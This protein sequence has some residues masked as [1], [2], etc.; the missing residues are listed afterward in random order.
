MHV[1]TVHDPFHPLRGREVREYRNRRRIC[2]LA[3]KTDRPFIVMVDGQP[4][5]RKDWDQSVGGDQVVIVMMLPEGGGGGGSSPLRIIGMLAVVAASFVVGPMVGGFIGGALG[6]GAAASAAIGSG[7]VLFGGSMLVNA[8]APAP[9]QNNSLSNAASAPA[10]SPT[11]S[12]QAQGNTARLGAPIPVQYGRMRIYPDFA[13]QPY[14]EYSDNEQYLYELLMI[15]QGEYSIEAVQIGNSPTTSFQNVTYEIVQPGAVPT[16]FPANVSQSSEVS[17]QELLTNTPVGPFV[18][19]AAGTKCTSIGIDVVCP[20]GLYY[21]NDGGGLDQRSVIFKIEARPIDQSGNPTGTGAWTT[22]NSDLQYTAWTPWTFYSYGL[23]PADT[24]TAHYQY[25]YDW[26]QEVF[27][28]LR[29]TRSLI[30][31]ANNSITGATTTPIRRSL[32]FDLTALGAG[33]SYPR[34]QVRVTR[35]DTKDTSSRA[36]HEIDWTGMRAYM[37]NT[38]NYGNVTMLAVKAQASNNL[39]ATS[40]RQ[41][42]VICTRKIKTVTAT[43]LSTTTSATRSMAAALADIATNTTYGGEISSANIDW[44]ALY[45][46]DQTLTARG[47]YLD[48]RFDNAMTLWEALTQ[49]GIVAR[50]KP[51]MQGGVLHFVRDQAATVPVALFSMR[52]IVQNSM[53]INYLTPTADTPDYTQVTYFDADTW[54]QTT[55]NCV[56]DGGTSN[57]PAKITLMGVTGRI[58][59]CREGLYQA[60]ANKYRRKVIKFSTEADGFIPAFGDLIAIA[61]D[62]PAWGQTAEVTNWASFTKTLTVNE[63]LTWTSGATHYIGL[64]KRDGSI[65]GPYVVTQGATTSMLVLATSPSFTPYTGADEERTHIA[66]GPGDTWRQPARV[67]SVMPRGPYQVEITAINEDANVH[68][69]DTTGTT[70]PLSYSQLPKTAPLPTVTGL[71]L[72]LDVTGATP[73]YVASW[74]A[75]AGADHYIVQVSW[76]NGASWTSVSTEMGTSHRWQANRNATATVRVAGVNFGVGTWNTTSV[77]YSAAPSTPIGFAATINSDMLALSWTANVE[78]DVIGYEVRTTNTGWG[79]T[80]A[81]FSG[82]AVAATVAPPAAGSA[83]TYYLRAIDFL[84]NYSSASA[85]VTFTVAAPSAVNSLSAVVNGQQLQVGWAKPASITTSQT[86][87]IGYEV[88]TADTNWGTSSGYLFKG[89]A[90][91]F[92]ATPPAAGASVTYYARAIDVR[93]NY[94]STSASVTFT[95]SALPNVASIAWSFY[96]T[97]TTSATITLNWTDVAPQFGLAGYQVSY[98]GN[99]VTV[100]ANSVTLP[101]NWIGDRA[102]TVKSVDLL[103]NVSSGYIATITKLAPASP[104][105]FRA[106]VV[107]NTVMLYWG[108]PSVT[109]LPISHYMMRRGAS[110]AGADVDYGRKD[111][112]FTTVNETAGGTYTYWIASVDTDGN[113]STPVNVSAVVSQPPDFVFFGQFTSTFSGTKS[114]ALLENNSLVLPVNTTETY[115]AHFTSHSWAGPSDQVTAGYPIFIQPSN[116]PGYYEEQFDFGTVLASSRVS[117]GYTATTVAGSP[118]M[119]CT[120]STSADGSTWLTNTGTTQI[121]ATS[122]RY[123][124][125][126]L[127]ATDSAGTGIFTVSNLNVT[128]DAKLKNDAGMTTCA[129][130]DASGTVANFNV[131][132][133]DVTSITVTPSSTTPVTAVYDFLDSVIAGTYSV[134]SNVATINATA[135]GLVAG[136]K[137]RLS[138]TSGTAPSGVYTVASVTNANTYTVALTTANTSGNVST[139]SQGLRIYLFNSAGTRVSGTASWSI[140]GY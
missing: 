106:Q 135:H 139:Y 130:T 97:S 126:R 56:L 6:L 129:S 61:H 81:V 64:R 25:I 76:D 128:L 52:N 36:G 44:A 1:V 105:N 40:A 35:T 107:D 93:G 14:V 42:N 10:A 124:K 49:A 46:I 103:G 48:V 114:S 82:S 101:A 32:K 16:L 18:S 7:L 50:T 34:F 78:L 132:F 23:P 94:S 117:I 27:V 121:F 41:V 113:L 75:A 19:N 112:L 79:G 110:W 86:T 77:D 13:S 109:T 63:P 54:Q 31:S 131:Q 53:T 26:G 29:S 115:A 102:F 127:T 72:V 38:V 66:F 140:K 119:A 120:I 2:K 84:G 9:T 4:V 74:N 83:T 104:T 60:A 37:P 68:T 88:R 80:G 11:Y 73:Q 125:V 71:S 24:D 98:T 59:A 69:A 118:V 95:S 70:P 43:G 65:A 51:F 55:V 91:S 138:F 47:D 90:L 137:V 111:G 57:T 87:V 99:S 108:Q 39:S 67:V 92:M 17:G 134:T 33:M 8:I 21:A 22:I 15:G 62:I 5:L 58:Q 100:K 136:Q 89:D 30:T 96:D 20:R 122:F 85:T 133:V 45:A 116:S 123:V 28:V 3:P 12:L